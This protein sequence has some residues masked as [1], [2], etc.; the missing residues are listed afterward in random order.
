VVPAEILLRAA[1]K[2]MTADGFVP[3]GEGRRSRH[4]TAPDNAGA[5]ELLD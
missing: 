2:K 1:A 4:K 5:F 3:D